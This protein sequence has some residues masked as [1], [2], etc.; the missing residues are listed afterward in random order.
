[1]VYKNVELYKSA[2]G[3]SPLLEVY[4]GNFFISFHPDIEGD[5]TPPEEG[6]TP[7]VKYLAYGSSIPHGVTATKPTD[8][9]AMKTAYLL[10]VNFINLG[11]GGGAHLEKEIADYIS[12]RNDWNFE[13]ISLN[14]SNIIKEKLQKKNSIEIHEW[15]F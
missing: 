9:H 7:K 14:L 5:V 13:K 2:D 3:V 10:G 11:L 4:Q 15:V 8:T 1:M 6:Q 12:E